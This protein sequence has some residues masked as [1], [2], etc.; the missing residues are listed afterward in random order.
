MPMPPSHWV[1]ER[2]RSSEWGS[3]E[4]SPRTVAPVVVSPLIASNKQFT[5]ESKGW[6]VGPSRA[7][8]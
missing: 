6:S 2:H 1:S 3:A 5:G 8:A 7:Q 4:I